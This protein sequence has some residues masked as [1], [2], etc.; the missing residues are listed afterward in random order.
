MLEEVP[1][2]SRMAPYAA[3][4]TAETV[5]TVGG[6]PVGSGRFV[7]L[8]DPAGQE[9]WDSDFRMV[10]MV[11]ARLDD[12][13]HVDPLLGTAAWS[14]L[15]DSLDDAGA[16]YHA[17]VG[18]VTRVLSETFGGLEL[19]DAC[20]HAEIRAS[21]SPAT[22]DLSPHLTAWY[23]LILMASGHEPALVR[24]LSLAGDRQ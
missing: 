21:W 13:V 12:E 17:L 11:R 5:H 19:S 18:T 3:A 10:V 6:T 2:P 15:T 24:P 14:W 8:H 22:A 7:I 1:A 23:E 9:S 16:G 4:L 20:G